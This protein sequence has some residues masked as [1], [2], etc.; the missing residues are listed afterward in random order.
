MRCRCAWVFPGSRQEG[1]RVNFT[2]FAAFVLFC[3]GALAHAQQA[4]DGLQ[5]NVP[6]LCN[7]GKV[8]VAHRCENG[9]NAESRSIR[10]RTKL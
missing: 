10:R 6:Y 4:P 5:F 1:R 7:D 3:I 2:R 9:P 8:Y